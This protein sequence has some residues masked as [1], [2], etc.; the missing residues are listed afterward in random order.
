MT[1]AAAE[2]S[3]A[4][5]GRRAVEF[6]RWA[7][8]EFGTPGPRPGT[9]LV[10]RS[11]KALTAAYGRGA[12]TVAW[13][14]S[15]LR[16][17]GAVLSSRPLVL[18]MTA[19]DGPADIAA[20][21]PLPDRP[22]PADARPELLELLARHAELVDRAAEL[23]ADMAAVQADIARAAANERL[24]D[25]RSSATVRELRGSLQEVRK[26]IANPPDLPASRPREPATADSRNPR[27]QQTPLPEVDRLVEP[28]RRLCRQTGRPDHL[29][30]RGRHLLA[31][32]PPSTL[33]SAV[34]TLI[35]EA[36]T[37]ARIA[38]PLGLLINRARNLDPSPAPPTVPADPPSQFEPNFDPTPSPRVASA[39]RQAATSP[40][41]LEAARAAFRSLRLSAPD[42]E[43]I[44]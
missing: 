24:A 39:D 22:P 1:A 42:S 2:P 37:D 14:V 26:E 3:P 17:A 19:L 28:L 23:V 11:Q 18:D 16:S 38:R 9:V 29:D 5:P 6:A 41:G 4:R 44:S 31:E 12:G 32:L 25:P 40:T 34:R 20:V 10:D 43:P 8:A 35:H 15:Q 36:T 30:T 7:A 21:V 27:P 33:E 13:Y